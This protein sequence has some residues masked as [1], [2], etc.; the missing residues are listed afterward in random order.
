MRMS[1]TK[2]FISAAPH[3]SL[4]DAVAS[5]TK[6]FSTDIKHYALLYAPHKCFLAI[7]D[8]DNTFR[9]EKDLIDIKNVYEARVFNRTAEL[10][11][12]NKENGF[13]KATVLCDT[14]SFEFLNTESKAFKTNIYGEDKELVGEI[15]QTYLLWGESIDG[16]KNGWTRFAEARIGSFYVPVDGIGASEKSRA[17]FRVI[18]YL[19]EYEDGNVAVCQERL[20]GIDRVSIKEKNHG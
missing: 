11:W 5:F 10:R 17:Q 12:R 3:L 1:E 9:N 6:N 13:G 2:L 15:K 4:A 19:G 7:V 18:E 8:R 16:S 14:D 20:C